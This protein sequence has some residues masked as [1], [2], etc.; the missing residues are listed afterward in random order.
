MVDLIIYAIPAFVLLLVV[1]ML[2]F[3]FAR[4]DEDLVGYESRDTRTSLSMGGGNVV[5]NA[6]WKLVVLFVF[7]GLYE[8]TPLRMPA[9]AVVDLGAAVLRRRPRLLL[10]PP[11]PPRGAGLLGEPRRPP[12]LAALQPLDR[13]APDLDADDG[14][15][16]LGA[17]GAARLRRPG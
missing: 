6:G 15:A 8:L 2:S 1:E 16:L 3:K 10:V 4:D 12:L 5:I 9:E 13:A 11:H 17:A 7:A 14:A